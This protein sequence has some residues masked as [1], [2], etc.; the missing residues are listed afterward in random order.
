MLGYGLSVFSPQ[1][2]GAVARQ[3]ASPPKFSVPNFGLRGP[4]EW[5]ALP[6]HVHEE[7][8]QGRRRRGRARASAALHF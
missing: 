2:Q 3:L 6:Q 8:T 7:F 5:G 4:I 1:L